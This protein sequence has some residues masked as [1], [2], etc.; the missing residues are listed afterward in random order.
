MSYLPFALSVVGFVLVVAGVYV[1][2]GTW[3]ALVVAGVLLI[4]DGYNATP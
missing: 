2:F 3:P 1:G 4:V